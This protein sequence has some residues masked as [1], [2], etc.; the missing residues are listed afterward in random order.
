MQ[1]LKSRLLK[2]D[3]EIPRHFDGVL[4]CMQASMQ[5]YMQGLQE[6]QQSVEI[7]SLRD[8][9][10]EFKFKSFLWILKNIA[11][12]YA[13]I[14]VYRMPNVQYCKRRGL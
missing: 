2:F 6:I 8:D 12:G 9:R 3:A 5:F 1:T 13:C 10:G 7:Y 4:N 14:H 11:Y